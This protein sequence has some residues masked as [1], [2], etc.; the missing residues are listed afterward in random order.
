M[1]EISEAH[2]KVK[3]LKTVGHFLP[4]TATT[5]QQLHAKASATLMMKMFV[6]MLPGNLETLNDRA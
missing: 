3:K 2:P 5:K 4:A 1:V 6:Y